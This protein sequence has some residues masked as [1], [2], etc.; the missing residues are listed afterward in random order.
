MPSFAKI[1]KARRLQTFLADGL[2][3]LQGIGVSQGDNAPNSARG[4]G[5]PAFLAVT[6]QEVDGL[7][8]TVTIGDFPD[9]D[10]ADNDPCGSAAC[11]IPSTA[12]RISMKLPGALSST[13]WAGALPPFP[14]GDDDMNRLQLAM[15]FLGR[16]LEELAFAEH[17]RRSVGKEALEQYRE[18]SVLQRAVV[19]L[20]ASMKFGDAAQAL[21]E[22]CKAAGLPADYCLVFGQED[23]LELIEK[24]YPDA[25]PVP[26]HFFS[27]LPKSDL[28]AQ[29]KRT[30]KSE[31]INEL[32]NDP[33]WKNECP[34]LCGLLLSPLTSSQFELG[35]LALVI[36][37]PD[38]TFSSAHLKKTTTLTSVAGICLANAYHFE[39][40]QYILLALVKAMATA[41]DARDRLTAGHSHRVAQ[42]ALGLAVAVDKDEDVCADLEFS[43][44]NFQE[45]FY[46]GLLHD[47]GKIGVREEVLTKETRLPRPHLELIGLR[48]ALWGEMN[49]TPWKELY[50]RLEIVNK[51]YDLTDEDN[52][53]VRQLCNESL[54]V[55][56]KTITILTEEEGQRL[57]TPRG[58]LTPSEWEE[59]KRHPQESHRILQNIPFTMHFPNILTMVLQHHERLDGSGYPE[60]LK[61]AEIGVQSRIMA[62]V[63]V[64]DAL[65]QDRHYKKGLS[66]EMALTILRQEAKRK[67]LD[68]RLVEIFCRDI[69]EIENTLV[70]S[71]DIM[72]GREFIQ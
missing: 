54:E 17:T 19:N 20:N 28:F 60:G 67:K 33:R 57:L 4:S 69:E 31:L 65:R 64:Y 70:M 53:L 13:L 3:L 5:V 24:M 39:Q 37:S 61:A 40:V 46:A 43:D 23:R 44:E 62:I 59:I 45:I 63:D 36:A 47:V 27:S 72:P 29:V 56:G 49:Q 1:F 10:A 34:Q 18:S 38:R 12:P 11:S 55:G 21:A 68:S 35:V 71:L 7:Y 15:D 30:K 42:Y 16:C 25:P 32:C 9:T 58:N 48:L 26:A 66:Q 2:A 51:A 41:I 50:A 8:H 22:E 6:W 14:Q 52:D